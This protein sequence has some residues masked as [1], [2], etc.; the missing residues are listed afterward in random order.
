MASLIVEQF[1]P[2]APDE[3]YPRWLAAEAL[4]GWWWPHIPD[5]T[6]DVAAHEGGSYA[7]RSEAAGIG[8]SGNYLKL[9]PPR[10]IVMTW[11]WEND[12]VAQVEEPVT[13]RFSATE[14]G[15]MV[16]VTH[17][18]DVIAG[19]PESLRQ[20]WEAVLGRLAYLS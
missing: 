14:D 12:G 15:T 11:I 18:V 16:R 8:V 2:A 5:T 13:V 10:E 1:V 20:G 4:A 9:D 17:E 6:Y 7:V 3:V 19:D